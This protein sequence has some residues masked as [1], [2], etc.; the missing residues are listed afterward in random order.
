MSVSAG[1]YGNLACNANCVSF[2]TSGCYSS[3]FLTQPIDTSA[4]VGSTASFS[5]TLNPHVTLGSIQWYVDN[6]ARR[7]EVA[8]NL[9]I[10]GAMGTSLSI[11]NVQLS[12]NGYLYSAV[13]TNSG[14]VSQTSSSAKLTVTAGGGGGGGGGGSGPVSG[15]GDPHFVGWN[16]ARFDFDGVDQQVFNLLSDDDVQLNA[17]FGRVLGAPR[18]Y[19][20]GIYMVEMGLRIEQHR[21]HIVAGG[22]LPNDYGTVLLD[23]RQLTL[24]HS[25]LLLNTSVELFGGAESYLEVEWGGLR[26]LHEYGIDDDH[27]LASYI[28]SITIGRRYELTIVLA[29]ERGR[30]AYERRTLALSGRLLDA[31]ATP[32]GVLGQTAGRSL[33]KRHL[34]DVMSS[35]SFKIE[36]TE[37]DYRIRDADDLFGTSFAFNRYTNDES[38][39]RRRSA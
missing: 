25:R 5:F 24:P 2:D 7:R 23:G 29:H 30:Y 19:L 32:H 22:H 11:S 28:V 17:R 39:R 36:G 21:V 35:S 6:L 13:V 38:R 8:V 3:F 14:G 33:A 20:A 18:R 27:Q 31:S 26:P 9:P 10:A 15:F 37:D 1:L 34:G 16:G 4:A 12:Q